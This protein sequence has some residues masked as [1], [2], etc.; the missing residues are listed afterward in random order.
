MSQAKIGR[1]PEDKFRVALKRTIVS[2]G[3]AAATALGCLACSVAQAAVITQVVFSDPTYADANWTIVNQFALVSAGQIPTGGHPDS[4][5][6]VALAVGEDVPFVGQI[7]RNFTYDPATNGAVTGITYN[8]DLITT[9][10]EGATYAPILVQNGKV[11]ADYGDHE[12]GSATSN[13]W[14]NWNLVLKLSSFAE[15]VISPS[16]GL[17]LDPTSQPNFS[18]APMTFGYEVTA[19]GGGFFTSITGIDNDPITLT[20]AGVPPGSVPEPGSLAG[21]GAGLAIMGFLKWGPRRLPRV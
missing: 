16:N 5:R 3:F 1:A 14:L 11:F 21:L 17:S 19:G 18:G 8:I 6:Q 2:A 10:A 13:T 12:T 9:N 15:L 4:Y 20:V 7:N